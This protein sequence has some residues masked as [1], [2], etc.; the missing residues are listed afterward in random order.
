MPDLP[1]LSDAEAARQY[2]PEASA[3]VPSVQAYSP[4]KSTKSTQSLSTREG[5]ESSLPA[6]SGGCPPG[7]T[8][9]ADAGRSAPRAPRR[10]DEKENDRDYGIRVA[11]GLAETLTAR[12]R[13]R[14]SPKRAGFELARLMVGEGY[15][16]PVGM[17]DVAEAFAAECGFDLAAVWGTFEM[18]WD[19]VHSPVGNDAFDVLARQA[20]GTT[21]VTISPDPGR[22]YFP[23]AVLAWLLYEHAGGESFIFSTARTETAFGIHR[24]T[25][26]DAVNIL[27]RRG[28]IACTDPRWSRRS[29]KA[30][31]FKFVAAV[32]VT[33]P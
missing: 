6:G 8:V 2:H 21:N 10:S 16:D 20:V 19:A 1:R 32:T 7:E 11:V 23:I 24:S 15:V 28:V 14:L 26:A 13:K 3:S 30:R 4:T 25:A 17:E 5:V 18:G 12:H 27:M 9:R 31:K 22:A 29:G 33:P